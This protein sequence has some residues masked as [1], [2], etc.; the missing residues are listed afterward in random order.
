MDKI[1]YFL[2]PSGF[3]LW[4]EWAIKWLEK[5]IHDNNNENIYCIHE[6]V[7][8]PNVVKHFKDKWIKFV[9]SIDEVNNKDSIIVFSAHWTN[10]NNIKKAEQLFKKVYNLECPLVNKVYKELESY[11]DQ[12]IIFYIGK[13]WHAEA[14]WVVWYANDL[15]KEIYIFNKIEDIPLIDKNSMIWVLSQTTLNFLDV[16]EIFS[17]I[18]K[19]YNFAVFPPISD[20]CKATFERQSVIKENIWRFSWIIIIWWKSSSNTKELC[21]IAEKEWKEVFFWENLDQILE[22]WKENILK[23]SK[24][25][26]TWW[27]S[28]P[29][30]DIEDML[31]WLLKRWYLKQEINFNK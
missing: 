5:I 19:N 14:E 2:K 6:I 27:A 9:D 22:Q 31:S 25:A 29:Y 11:K 15:W 20:V 17:E 28:T 21:K 7:H 8:N 10:R 1:V 18:K 13:K 12:N 4:V 3:C 24:I 30:N 26:I 23:H 16:K